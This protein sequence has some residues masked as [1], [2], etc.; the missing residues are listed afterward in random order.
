MEHRGALHTFTGK[1]H[2]FCCPH[3]LPVVHLESAG[4]VPGCVC[5]DGSGQNGGDSP[6]AAAHNVQ[7]TTLILVGP[8]GTL[9]LRPLRVQA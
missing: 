7:L 1:S 2:R 3:R 8:F 4:V 9:D 6:G 5:C